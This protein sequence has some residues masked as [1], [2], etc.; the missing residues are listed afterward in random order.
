MRAFYFGAPA[1][2]LFGVYDPPQTDAGLDSSVVLCY[3]HG[4]EYVSAFRAY[5]TL[6]MRLAR[7]GF[8]VLRFDYLGT[9]D[10]AGDIDQA[11]PQQWIADVIAAVNEVRSSLG[12]SSVSLVG[13]RLGATLAALAATECRAVDRLVL[14][15]PVVQ[16]SE[17][18]ASLR[19]RHSEWLQ[20]EAKPRPRARLLSADEELLGYRFTEN[21]RNDLERVNLWSVATRP[22]RH[23]LIVS[24][25]DNAEHIRLTQRLQELDA[26]VE[27][28]RVE[29]PKIWSTTPGMEQ[30]LVPNR[31]LQAIAGWLGRPS[32]QRS[33]VSERLEDQV[34]RV[35]ADVLGLPLASVTLR[36]SRDHVKNWDSLNVVNLAMAIEAEFGLALTPEEVGELLSVEPIVAILRERGLS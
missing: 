12:H 29:G 20:A 3:P 24:Q 34:R 26:N 7:A 16:G 15:E 32:G 5:R 21:L 33:N 28:K 25:D 19:A 23:V 1:R 36:T 18:L 4:R 22:A 30:G 31:V 17:Y 35:V 14:W 8:H 27:V 6:A 9:G 13:L 11:S 2:R 10:S